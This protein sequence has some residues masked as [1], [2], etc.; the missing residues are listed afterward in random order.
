MVHPTSKQ[1]RD[2]EIDTQSKRRRNRYTEQ[3]DIQ[4]SIVPTKE[5]KKKRK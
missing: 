4:K 2:G 1:A 3:R 5:M